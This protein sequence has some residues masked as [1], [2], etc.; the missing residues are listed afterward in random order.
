MR[1]VLAVDFSAP[2]EVAVSE[3]VARPWPPGTVVHVLHILDLFALTSSVGYF[4]TFISKQ[5]EEAGALARSIAKRL[6]SSGL[7]TKT[8]I[9]EGYPGAGISDYARKVNADFIFVGSHGHSGIVRL[10]LGSVAKLVVQNAGCSVEIVRAS[11]GR[12]AGRGPRGACRGMEKQEAM[13][14]KR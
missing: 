4:D 3:V 5:A 11:T 12:H 2:S 14:C 1:I 9:I 8:E 13:K 6:Q 7:E 10:L